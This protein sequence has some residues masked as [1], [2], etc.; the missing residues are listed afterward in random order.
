MTLSLLQK[1]KPNPSSLFVL[2]VVLLYLMNGVWVQEAVF[3]AR[4]ESVM[5]HGA[6]G[7]GDGS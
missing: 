5:A 1:P 7:Y 3:A 4:V 2:S 6:D